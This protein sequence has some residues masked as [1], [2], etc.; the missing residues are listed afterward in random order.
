VPEPLIEQFLARVVTELEGVSEDGGTTYWYTPD[1]VRRAEFNDNV[2]WETTASVFYEVR[3]GEVTLE[4]LTTGQRHRVRVELF[5]TVARKNRLHRPQD[6]ARATVTNR[7]AHDVKRMLTGYT[8]WTGLCVVSL[9]PTDEEH[10]V[11]SDGWAASHLRFAAEIIE[12][13]T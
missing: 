13:Y 10:D 1:W 8:T 12:S 4:S 3:L 2:K 6:G 11:Q 7:L 5:V 9:S